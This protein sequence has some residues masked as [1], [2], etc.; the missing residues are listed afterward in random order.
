MMIRAK[1]PIAANTAPMIIPVGFV[2]LGAVFG[3]VVIKVNWR[4]ECQHGCV[5]D[6]ESGY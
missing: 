6:R 1:T 4:I 3:G 5:S 2:S